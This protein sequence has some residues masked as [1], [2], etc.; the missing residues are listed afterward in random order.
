MTFI[1][2]LLLTCNWEGLSLVR[3]PFIVSPTNNV[4]AGR[5]FL[6]LISHKAPPLITIHR[7]HL[8]CYFLFRT[9]GIRSYVNS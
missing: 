7:I 5:D 1:Y 3:I 6:N 2:K 8:F 9:G 4:A